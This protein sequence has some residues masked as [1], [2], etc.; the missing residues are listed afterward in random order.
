MPSDAKRISLC[1]KSSA[2]TFY[3]QVLPAGQKPRHNDV[4]HAEHA[5][6]FRA[7]PSAAVLHLAKNHHA[8]RPQYSVT[9]GLRPRRQQRG[10]LPHAPHGRQRLAAQHR[11]VF[12]SHAIRP[13]DRRGCRRRRTDARDRGD[14]CYRRAV[15][16]QCNPVRLSRLARARRRGRGN[17]QDG[18]SRQPE[19]ALFLRPRHGHHQRL[20]RRTGHPGVSG[21]HHAGGL[22]CHDAESHRI[23]E[24]DGTHHRDGGRSGRRVPRGDRP[25][26]ES[27]AR[28]TPDRQKQPRRYLQH[29]R[30]DRDRSVVR[31]TAALPVRAATGRRG[32]PDQRGISRA[33][34]AGRLG[35]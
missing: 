12:E 27:R 11:A 18:E 16:L 34:A 31:A 7:R 35:A 23:A 24:A 33:H 19:S 5:C 8:K 21:E 22:R 1:G 2:T 29:A 17:C 15:A 28:Q 25:R 20:H 6:G 13:L 32:R 4:R 26:S 30:R 9:R 3:G 10:G 14:W